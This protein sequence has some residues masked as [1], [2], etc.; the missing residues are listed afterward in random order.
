M[1]L[2]QSFILLLALTPLTHAKRLVDYNGT[3]L[4]SRNGITITPQTSSAI[5]ASYTQ[6]ITTAGLLDKTFGVG[7]I[8]QNGANT[9]K[10]LYAA[11]LQPDGKI[12]AAGYSNPFKKIFTLT[13]LNTDGSLD[14]SFGTNG[15]VTTDVT[16]GTS[17]DS[18]ANALLLQPDGKIIAV[19]Y[20]K[21]AG[22]PPR[23]TVF[24]LV[25]YNQN[26]SL[27]TTFNGTGIVTTDINPGT[28]SDALAA[29]LQPDG[30]I[31]AAGYSPVGGPQVFTLARY[32]TD[33][34]P[35]RTFGTT[36]SG[37]VTTTTLTGS[38]IRA[39]L[40]QPD[41][42]IIALGSTVI[43]GHTNFALVRYN[44]NGSVDSTFNNGNPVTTDLAPGL[45]SEINAA[46]LQSNGAIVAGGYAQIN[47]G[48]GVDNIFSL[49][50]YTTNGSLDT[51]FGSEGIVMTN[52][53]NAS[54]SALQALLS[55]PDDTIVAGGYVLFNATNRT[56]ALVCYNTDGS[57]N[58]NFGTGGTV[59]TDIIP[60]IDNILQA[61]L[62]QPDNKILAVGQSGGSNYF[63]LVR[64]INP[65]TLASFTASYGNVGLV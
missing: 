40:L 11:V 29:L 2:K 61:L 16:P 54:E 32:N 60:G 17:L 27:D 52:V 33:G 42:K 14:N 46:V 57:L 58:Q 62:L 51:K 49:A 18:Q 37:I 59:V 47:T 43:D 56:F 21:K 20:G 38:Q 30:K 7:G 6:V 19:G 28:S 13:R 9:L 45:D 5:R 12:I 26:G 44:S 23:K 15:V 22:A 10:D 36:N 24:A 3:P 35:D 50:R 53:L 1:R 25:R 63:A 4:N 64:Y 8:V 31:I 48:G 65:F 39:A 41:N 55:Q 34:S